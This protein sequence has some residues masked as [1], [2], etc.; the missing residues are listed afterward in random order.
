[1]G[2]GVGDGVDERH[3]L[4]VDLKS[5]P[6]PKAMSWGF[7]FFEW[8]SGC[9]KAM[10]LIGHVETVWLVETPKNVLGLNPDA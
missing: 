6:E 3:N 5:G 9:W 7:P 1:M 8:T 2:E 4:E 10:R